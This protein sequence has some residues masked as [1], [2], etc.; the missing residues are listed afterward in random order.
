MFKTRTLGYDGH[1]QVFIREPEDLRKCDQYLGSPAILEQ[2]IKFDY[3][4]S[5]VMVSDG[6]W[7]INFPIGQNI[8]RDGILDLCI[9]PAPPLTGTVRR[10]IE[11]LCHGFLRN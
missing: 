1:G 9:V 3:E 6:K 4:A 10:K 11:E 5:I 7:I 8:H 2:F